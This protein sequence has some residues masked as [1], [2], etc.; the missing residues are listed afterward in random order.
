MKRKSLLRKFC[1]LML[2]LAMVGSASGSMLAASMQEVTGNVQG[3]VKDQTGAVI[4]GALVTATSEQRSY[5]ATT[6][7]VGQYNLTALQP[8]VYIITATGTGFTTVRR[9]NVTVELG[10]T[11][12]VNFELQA[13]AKGESVVVTSSDEPIVDVTSTKIAT[14]ITQKEIDVLPKGLNM[15]SVL[16]TAPGTRGEAKSGG[17]QIDGASGSENVFIIDGVE[18]TDVNVGT[19]VASKDIPTSFLKEVQVKSAGYEAEFG[20][21]TGGVINTVTRG[22][23]ND[24]HGEIGVDYSNDKMRAE[25]NPVLR[26]N[27]INDNKAEFFDNPSGKDKNTNV[28]PTF[29]VGGPI[30][31]DKFWFFS[32]YSPQFFYTTRRL[33]LIRTTPGANREETLSSRFIDYR[34]KNDFFMTRLDASPMSKLSVSATF[35]NSPTKQNGPPA[36]LAFQTSS[37]D[38]FNN[39]RYDQQGG[40]NPAWQVSGSATYSLRSNLILS[41]RGGH[42]YDNQKGGSYD[43]PV[44][45]P[46][47]NIVRACVAPLS[48]CAAGTTTVGAPGITNNFATKFDQL[49]RTNL[50]FDA[51]YVKQIFGQ[52][53]VLKGGYQANLLSNHVDQG[54]VGAGI[55][56][57]YFNSSFDAGLGAGPERG[58]YGYYRITEFGTV[59]KANSRNQGFFIQDSWSPHRRVTLNLGFRA[60]NEYLPSFPIN[61]AFH[62]SLSAEDIASAPKQPISFGWGDKLAPRLGAAWDVFGDGKLKLYGSYSVFFDTMKYQLARGSFGAD[63]FL[64]SWYR[65]EQPDFRGISVNNR[66]GKQ[67]GVTIDFRVPSN[68][69]EPGAAPQVDPNLKP[70]REHEYTVGADYAF[71][72]DM[73]FSARLT[74]KALDRTIEDVGAAD[75]FGNEIYTIGNPGFGTTV[76]YFTALGFPATP[77]ARREYTGLELRVAK[78]FTRH[79]GADVSYIY[80]KLYGNYSGLASSDENGRTS[81]NVNRFFDLPELIYDTHGKELLGRL[82]TDRPNTFKGFANYTL[83]WKGMETDFGVFQQIFQGIPIST[84]LTEHV[85]PA[86]AVIFPEGR[87]DLGRTPWFTQTDLLINHRIKLN[88]RVALKLSLDVNNLFDERNVTNTFNAYLKADQNVQYTDFND[89]IHSNGDWRQRVTAQGKLLDPRFGLPVAFQGQRVARFNIGVQF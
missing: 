16:R 9:D 73:M 80:S 39:P 24:W 7:D 8:G 55:I 47:V 88:E 5:K 54:Y 17:F 56:N 13:S 70:V 36:F 44:G 59:G 21:A 40:Y 19:L 42:N 22:G 14:N 68:V 53:H 34:T 69:T 41:F 4:A 12:Q 25:D 75:V 61:A 31:K 32:S 2:L 29:A 35:I 57:F 26:L 23:T 66:P 87:G 60:E 58:A 6:N 30:V 45:V 62:P 64:R 43:I 72:K 1:T 71:A 18:V 51:T 10:R 76:D 74:R 77:K 38:N 52:Q 37:L 86:G 82:A 3:A 33:D 28:N 89:F 84:N 20:G 67:I 85:G 50:N 65:L 63:L 81:P 78:R 27:L 79:W 46:V 48:G 15:Q 49:R 11:L 83:N